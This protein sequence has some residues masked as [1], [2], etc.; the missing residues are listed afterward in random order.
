[1]SNDLKNTVYTRLEAILAAEKITREELGHMSRELLTYVP[2]TDDIDIVNRL[3]AGLTTVNA[4]AAVLFFSH[5]LPWE[6]EK[7]NDGRHVRFGKR[8]QGEKKLARS[9]EAIKEFLSEPGNTI[10]TWADTNIEVKAP[11]YAARVVNAINGAMKGNDKKGFEGLKPNEIVAAIF[12]SQLN[13]TDLMAGLE[14]RQQQAR[15]AFQVIE[16]DKE[17]VA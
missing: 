14:V 1:M 3:V 6:Q 7:D 16:G 15:E 2:E 11:D 9:V 4:K 17:N 12:Q 8:T 10:W 13:M 5:F